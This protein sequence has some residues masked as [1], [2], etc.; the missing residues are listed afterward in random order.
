MHFS[1][2]GAIL[3]LV[4]EKF[5]SDLIFTPDFEIGYKIPIKAFWDPRA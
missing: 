5:H 1:E 3:A 4:S 2:G